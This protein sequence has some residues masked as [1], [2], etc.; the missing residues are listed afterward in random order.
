MLRRALVPKGY[1][2]T[3]DTDI[4]KMLDAI[5]DQPIDEA[6]LQR[7]LRKINA[8]EPMFPERFELVPVIAGELTAEEQEVFVLCRSKNKPLPPDLAAKVKA[9]EEKAAKRPGPMGDLPRG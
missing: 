8:Q 4:E 5:G 9:L 7:M 6:T 2:P 3:K 1:R